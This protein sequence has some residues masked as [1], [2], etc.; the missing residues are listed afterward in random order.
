M[1]FEAF[2]Q[3]LRAEL[4][5]SRINELEVSYEALLGME[6]DETIDHAITNATFC[7]RL[8]IERFQE[9]VTELGYDYFYNEDTCQWEL[10]NPE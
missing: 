8:E 5:L 2:E 4:Y 1:E 10:E 3:G 6:F 9:A 7:V